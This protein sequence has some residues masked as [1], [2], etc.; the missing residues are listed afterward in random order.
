VA[1]RGAGWAEELR[2]VARET[3]RKVE[4]LRRVTKR[5]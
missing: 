4:P 1:E 3:A 2:E 5:G